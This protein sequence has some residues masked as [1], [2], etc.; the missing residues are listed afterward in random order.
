ISIPGADLRDPL[1]N[2]N[3][4]TLHELQQIVRNF[5]F[6]L[7]LNLFMPKYIT[8]SE[9][10]IIVK[11]YRITPSGDLCNRVCPK[12]IRVSKLVDTLL[13]TFV[14]MLT[15]LH[16]MNDETRARAIDKA[17]NI[18]KQVA[19][20]TIMTNEE[21]IENQ[22]AQLEIDKNEFLQSYL[23]IL[24]FR[25][26][27]NYDK[28]NELVFKDRWTQVRI[29]NAFY[30]ESKNQIVI[31]A[32][33]IEA[34]F[35]NHNAPME[36]NFSRIGMVIGHEIIHSFD[37][38]RRLYDKHGNLN[39]WWE[40]KTSERFDQKAQCVIDQYSSYTIDSIRMNVDGKLTLSENIADNGGIKATNKASKQYKM[41]EGSKKILPYLNMTQ[42]QLFFLNFA[43]MCCS[44]K[45]KQ[46]LVTSL[47]TDA[48]SPAE[49]RVIGSLSNSYDFA[50][51]YNCPSESKMN[52][53]KKC[54]VW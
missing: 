52:P 7:Y 39:D 43:Q 35:F 10:V 28:I 31:P 14:N 48:H 49:I 19:Y 53:A 45:S 32:G 51:A 15:N 27:Q 21:Y 13:D 17:K 33:I 18:D 46:A 6:K 23:N 29:V 44:S 47:F 37:D 50:R 36:L 34:P 24:K 9:K 30:D 3:K 1:V 16:W 20:P 22:Y 8:K 12:W 38:Q 41:N 54:S 4:M 5:N 40:N 25:A 11:F 26:K 2:Y 42:E